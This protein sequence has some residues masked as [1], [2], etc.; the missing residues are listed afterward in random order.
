[1]TLTQ[2]GELRGC[3]GT[4]IARRPLIEDVVEN[5]GAAA[6]EDYRFAPLRE[7]D[8]TTLEIAISLLSP[9]LPV[10]AASEALLLAQ[11]RPKIDGLLLQDGRRQALFLPQVWTYLPKPA[12]FL[13]QLRIKA[14]LPRDHWSPS[15]RFQR[16]TSVTARESKQGGSGEP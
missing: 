14:G 10:M 11:L 15:L 16:F 3:I 1:M 12:D 2:G 13:A 7:S 8:L 5:A 6:T 9:P 4:P